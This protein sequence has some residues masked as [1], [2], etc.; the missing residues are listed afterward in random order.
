MRQP[1]FCA[2]AGVFGLRRDRFTEYQPDRPLADKLALVAAVPGV[3]GVELKYPADFAGGQPVRALLEQAGLALAAV[4][5]DLKDARYFRHGA[6][7]ATD[8]AARARAVAR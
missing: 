3:S 6:L 8:A 7:S 1:R 4:N 2:N 5:V